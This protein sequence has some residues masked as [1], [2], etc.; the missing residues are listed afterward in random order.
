MTN[1]RTQ[2]NLRLLTSRNKRDGWYHGREER[3]RRVHRWY[4]L[5]NLKNLSLHHLRIT[6]R[7][8]YEW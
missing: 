2:S 8:H 1:T 5:R 4:S 3:H 6:R 7:S